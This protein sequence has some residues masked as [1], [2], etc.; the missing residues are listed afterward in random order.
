MNISS[1]VSFLDYIGAFLDGDGT[2]STT[3]ITCY[4]YAGD[5]FRDRDIITRTAMS[6]ANSITISTC[7]GRDGA[8]AQNDVSCLSVV[9]GT[10]TSRSFI[11][12]VII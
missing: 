4:G 7:C 8:T 9:S 11:C 3:D 12:S 2:S 10:N 5:P 6:S 1:L